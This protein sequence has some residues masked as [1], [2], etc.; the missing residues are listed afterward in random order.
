M[1]QFCG[2]FLIFCVNHAVTNQYS[3][4]LNM[5]RKLIDLFHLM[6]EI[7]AVIS[8]TK[9]GSLTMAVYVKTEQIYGNNWAI[10]C[11]PKTVMIS[12]FNL[13]SISNSFGYHNDFNKYF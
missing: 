7:E 13:L 1:Y 4:S 11:P 10:N 3:K 2:R 5:K 8:T 12:P 9:F 6:Q